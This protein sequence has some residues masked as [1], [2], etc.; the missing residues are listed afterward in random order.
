MTAVPI[1]TDV[2]GNNTS[3][4]TI[5]VN[6]PQAPPRSFV[7]DLYHRTWDR[8]LK[9][10]LYAGSSQAGPISEVVGAPNDSVIEG[11]Y[12]EYEVEDGI[13]GRDFIYNRLLATSCP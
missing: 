1:V 11:E 5:T 6:H 4:Y 8:T 2:L 3:P 10:C 7:A 9:P 13:F 12:F